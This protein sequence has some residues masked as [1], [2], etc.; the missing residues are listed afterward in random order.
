MSNKVEKLKNKLEEMSVQ[1]EEMS[2][3]IENIK[4][5]LE[6]EAIKSE[7]E[8]AEN[9]DEIRF[10]NSGHYIDFLGNHI[11]SCVSRGHYFVSRAILSATKEHAREI[12][13]IIT[14]QRKIHNIA[15]QLDPDWEPDWDDFGQDKYSLTFNYKTNRYA[16]VVNTTCDRS[17]VTFGINIIEKMLHHANVLKTF[18]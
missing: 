3:Q 8:K 6:I 7:L 11:T 1:I 10:S 2:F 14:T 4:S 15:R 13:K 16:V 17:S 12:D 18:D 5:D 9:G